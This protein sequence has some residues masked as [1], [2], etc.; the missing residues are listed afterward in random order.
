MFS[1]LASWQLPGG[2]VSVMPDLEEERM[3]AP[4]GYS[5]VAAGTKGEKHLFNQRRD[6]RAETERGRHHEL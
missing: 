4:S 5:V 2:Q 3:R 1:D 6:H